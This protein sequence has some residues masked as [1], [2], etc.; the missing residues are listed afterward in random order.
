VGS[1]FP[2]QA[3]TLTI[4]GSFIHAAISRGNGEASGSTWPAPPIKGT[5]RKRRGNHSRQ[6]NEERLTRK[7]N[8]SNSALNGQDGCRARKWL[9]L[10]VNVKGLPFFRGL[11]Q[12]L[13]GRRDRSPRMETQKTARLLKRIFV[14]ARSDM[15]QAPHRLIY[16]RA[17]LVRVCVGEDSAWECGF[18]RKRK[19]V[20]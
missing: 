17:S 14:T 11:A 13:Q 10:Y 3:L 6:Q 20:K 9:T 16:M 8:K 7:P 18:S 1:D 19:P 12:V 15:V 5:G 4:A 2:G